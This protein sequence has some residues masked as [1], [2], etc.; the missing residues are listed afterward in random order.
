[1][2]VNPEEMNAIRVGVLGQSVDNTP[3]GPG[4]WT[5]V[6][7]TAANTLNTTER[8]VNRALNS[9]ETR[10]GGA[11]STTNGFATRFTDVIGEE[12]AADKDAFESL[13]MNLIQAIVALKEG[14]GGGDGG[15]A[16]FEYEQ[17]DAATTW[18]IPHNLGQR[19]VLVQVIGD[20]GNTLIGD[21]AYT[22]NDVVTL[23]FS[24]AVAGTAIVRR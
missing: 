16:R 22:S 2:A 3:T 23:T 9:I 1:M 12:A 24:N 18:T 8:I 15:A 7:P 17:E 13:G 5:T 10:L 4:G 6:P 14:G 21:T 19:Y 20:T 11:V